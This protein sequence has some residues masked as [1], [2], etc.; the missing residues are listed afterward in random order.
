MT[1]NTA[2]LDPINPMIGV[3]SANSILT[4]LERHDVGVLRTRAVRMFIHPIVKDP[5]ARARNF[6]EAV[7]TIKE[8]IPSV[9][10]EVG[11][12]LKINVEQLTELLAHTHVRLEKILAGTAPPFDKIGTQEEVNELA[13]TNKF[14]PYRAQLILTAREVAGKRLTLVVTFKLL[15]R[16][17][18]KGQ[19]VY[20][21][22]HTEDFT[23]SSE[24]D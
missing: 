16:G 19:Y 2:T 14:L 10:N 24:K 6:E 13:K 9:I 5:V 22:V 20:R 11:S 18:H 21:A 12:S 15:K 8:L 4:K 17:D 7:L 3:L 1:T 23:A